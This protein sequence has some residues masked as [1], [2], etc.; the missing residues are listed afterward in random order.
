[1]GVFSE[2]SVDCYRITLKNSATHFF[3]ETVE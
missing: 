3:T 1:V 2:Q